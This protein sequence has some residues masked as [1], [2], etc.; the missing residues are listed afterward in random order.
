MTRGYVKNELVKFE[1]KRNSILLYTCENRNA[2]FCR[3]TF[4]AQLLVEWDKR[5]EHR[6]KGMLQPANFV[7]LSEL[8]VKKNVTLVVLRVIEWVCFC[9]G[10][11]NSD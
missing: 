3:P 5:F 4:S 1:K 9:N 10:K 7:R 6:I 11:K 2:C 8:M